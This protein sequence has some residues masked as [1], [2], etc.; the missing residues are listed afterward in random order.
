MMWPWGRR[1][2]AR[3]NAARLRAALHPDRGDTLMIQ[4]GG[5]PY[6]PRRY[7]VGDIIEA[8]SGPHV[9]IEILSRDLYLAVRA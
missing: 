8:S 5:P 7:R 2:R 1:R 4:A 3:V 9:I 6:P